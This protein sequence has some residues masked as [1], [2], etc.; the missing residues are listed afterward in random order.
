MRPTQQLSKTEKLK[1]GTVAK[2]SGSVPGFNSHT[3]SKEREGGR[4]NPTT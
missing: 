4:M 2:F 3:E 1:N